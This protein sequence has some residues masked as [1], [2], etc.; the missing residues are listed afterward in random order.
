[1]KDVHTEHCCIRHGCKYGNI[2]CTVTTA[3][4]KQSYACEG[5]MDEL[6]ETLEWA[7]LMNEM[8]EAGRSFGRSER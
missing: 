4:K 3:E 6:E 5:C 7:Y 2:Y 8:F 1:M